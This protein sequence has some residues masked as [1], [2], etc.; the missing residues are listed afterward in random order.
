METLT[1]QFE[2]NIKAKILEI[3]NSFPSNELKIV[4]E[5]PVFAANKKM[6]DAELAKIKNGT[7]KLYSIDEVDEYLDKI[8]SEYEN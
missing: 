5:D 7:A 4:N 6:L 3:L 8:I 1:I 2:S